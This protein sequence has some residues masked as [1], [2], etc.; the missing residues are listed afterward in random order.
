MPKVKD[1]GI[2][3]SCVAFALSTFLEEEYK[4]EN[5]QFSTGFIYG[6]RPL[7]Y[8]QEE[9]MYPR[10]AIKT[11]KN[12]GDC[13][14]KFFEH[15]KEMPEVKELVDKDIEKLK[16]LSEQ[17]KIESY[18]RIYTKDEIK[19]VLIQDVP[20]PISIPVYGDIELDENNIIQ[21]TNKDISGYHMM[22]IYGWNES[23]FL[24]QN[25]WGKDW[26]DNGTA[27]LPYEYEIDSAWAISTMENDILTY[28]TIWQKI[29]NKISEFIDFLYNIFIY[30][31]SDLN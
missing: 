25:S 3:N 26:G 28:Q 13:Q 30:G 12:V 1:Q 14:Y 4:Y 10:E 21:I 29:K 9:G 19:N 16:A 22:I 2:V 6:Y 31:F 8:N 18:A 23:G 24:I 15:N 11:L 17:Y 27:I 7:G 5:K 20:V